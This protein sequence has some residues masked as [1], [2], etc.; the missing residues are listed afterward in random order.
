M[1]QHVNKDLLELSGSS[2]T[3]R[4]ICKLVT[5]VDAVLDS[6]MFFRILLDETIANMYYLA[7]FYC[8]GQLIHCLKISGNKNN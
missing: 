3:G 2:G 4:V 7:P 5:F 6:F 8:S 1:Y